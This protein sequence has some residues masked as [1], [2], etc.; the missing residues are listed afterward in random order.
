MNEREYNQPSGE[1]DQKF[2]K[3]EH[4]KEGKIYEVVDGE[5]TK[6]DCPECEGSG[7]LL[8]ED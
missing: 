2:T 4:C 1:P 3:C 6:E 5:L 7:W 8:I